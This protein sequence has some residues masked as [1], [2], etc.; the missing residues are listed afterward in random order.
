M[1]AEM[2]F[3]EAFSWTGFPQLGCWHMAENGSGQES[4]AFSC[5]MP[6][7]LHQPGLASHIAF[8]FLRRARW[9]REQM[10][11]DLQDAAMIDVLK[12]RF[13]VTEF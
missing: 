6:N 4:L 7:A 2:N 9:A 8:W 5:F 11:P 3:A 13:G 12:R 1:A 10:F